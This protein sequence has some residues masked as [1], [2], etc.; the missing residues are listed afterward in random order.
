MF[1][2]IELQQE[3]QRLK[4]QLS[5]LLQEN[6]ALKTNN[7]ALQT[8]LTTTQITHQTHLLEQIKLMRHRAF[9]TKSEAN[10]LQQSLFDE[11]GVADQAPLEPDT[12]TITYTRKKKGQ[13]HRVVLA[14]GLEQVEIILDIDEADKH[15]PCCDKE[16]SKMGEESNRALNYHSR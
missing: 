4:A 3:N 9:G 5:V 8:K 12:Q 7:A 16:R 14:E 13:G 1:N 6:S 2:G 11:I 15:C 10:L